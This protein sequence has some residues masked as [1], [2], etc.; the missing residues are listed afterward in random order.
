[1][2]P[3]LLGDLLDALAAY[4][5]LLWVIVPLLLAAFT[6]VYLFERD[7]R[8][9]GKRVAGGIG[10]IGVG[11]VAVATGIGEGLAGAG[12][13]AIEVL[14]PHLDF[15]AQLGIAW[16]GWSGLN[17]GMMADVTAFAV[18]VVLLIGVSL[19]WSE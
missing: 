4:A 7:A 11:F 13:G 17:G 2:T 18:F 5:W 16:A 1:M 3:A 15:L 6:F 12:G 10:A 8:T 19:V 9:S 14:A